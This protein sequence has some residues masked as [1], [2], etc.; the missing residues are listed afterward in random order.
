MG[1]PNKRF[2]WFFVSFVPSFGAYLL[3]YS[4]SSRFDWG[5][6][7][8]LFAVAAIPVLLIAWGI[9]RGQNRPLAQGFIWGLAAI[10]MFLFSFGGCGL[11]RIAGPRY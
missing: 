3:V 10:F 7:E 1:K 9:A 5:F 11:L 4:R 6:P 2:L 8:F